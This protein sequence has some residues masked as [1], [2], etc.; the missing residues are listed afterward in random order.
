MKHFS[1]S[2][3]GSLQKASPNQD[4]CC[5]LNQG[6]LNCIA[7]ADGAGSSAYGAVG[8]QLACR[9]ACRALLRSFEQLYCCATPAQ[10]R[11]AV[12]SPVLEQLHDLAKQLGFSD[13]VEKLASTLLVLCTDEQD[14]R[15]ICLHLGDG[16]AIR[17]AEGHTT[18][19]SAPVNGITPWF[20]DLTSSPGCLARARVHRGRCAGA[21]FVLMSD[22]CVSAL[23]NAGELAPFPRLLFTMRDWPAVAH[24][25]QTT[26][27]EDDCS[28]IALENEGCYNFLK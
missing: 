12:L 8:A 15:Y 1:F 13:G 6:A 10:I 23:G 26:V 20:T 22:G 24:M 16:L 18:V 19:L 17:I 14:G 7:L 2:Q 25:L 3:R 27:P 4:R 5:S 9:A 11:L 21:S 28:F